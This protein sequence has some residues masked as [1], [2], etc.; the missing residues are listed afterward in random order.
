MADETLQLDFVTLD[1]FTDVRFQGNPLAV[2]LVPARLRARLTQQARQRIA[3]E[4]NLSETV[5]LH[6]APDDDGSEPAGA[7]EIDINIHTVESELPFAGH[8]TVGAAYLVLHHL[9]WRR[10]DGDGDGASA[11]LRTGAGPIRVA[12]DAAGGAAGA[13][14]LVRAAVPHAVRVHGNT[15]GGVLGALA[16]RAP[17]AAAAVERGLSRGPAVRAAELAAPI[18]SIV[19][20]M[21]FLLVR[22]P[23]LDHL[24]RVAAGN[25]ID[26][27]L[28]PELL[29]QGEWRGGFVSRYYYVVLEEE[30]ERKGKEEEGGGPAVAEGVGG[31]ARTQR[32]VALRTRMVELGFEDPATG[33]AACALASYLTIAAGGGGQSRGGDLGAR[34]V[35][36]QGVEMGRPS[37][38]TVD[39]VAR[40]DQ[41]SGEVGIQ[42][43]YLAG[44]A[45]VVMSGR[46]SV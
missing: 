31:D 21:A 19:R 13:G 32:K 17:D 36:T 37:E 34:F 23:S 26:F 27:G 5:F 46:I 9:G 44:T 6:H 3:R 28:V 25:R 42:E 29:D 15:L 38:I 39:T 8:P 16:S 22:L 45:V 20:G 4:F 43:V 10:G 33:S 24:A 30:Q 12:P 40:V 11:T 14:A 18:V 7:R 1:V 41:E 35:I 2:V